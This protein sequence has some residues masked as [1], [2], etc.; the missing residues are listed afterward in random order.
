M[1]TLSGLYLIS[2]FRYSVF[3]N[4][5]NSLLK[6]VSLISNYLCLV[7]FH[8]FLLGQLSG[9][10]LRGVT[11]IYVKLYTYMYIEGNMYITIL[12]ENIILK[13]RS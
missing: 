10:L 7:F 11:D 5:K 2:K 13:S 12:A 6:L 3:P 8:H 1:S 9:S 4:E